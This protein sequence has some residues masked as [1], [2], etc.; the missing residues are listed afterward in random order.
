ME[1]NLIFFGIIIGKVFIRISFDIV[2][3]IKGNLGIKYI[4]DIFNFDGCFW[5]YCSM[6]KLEFCVLFLFN[7]EK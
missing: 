3:G 2:I 1:R 7:I 5:C 4:I 6:M